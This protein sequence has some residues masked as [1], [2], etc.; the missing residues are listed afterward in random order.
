[1]SF[2]SSSILYFLLMCDDSVMKFMILFFISSE[3][4]EFSC[5]RMNIFV[6]VYLYVSYDEMLLKIFPTLLML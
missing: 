4:G 2:S 3:R 1:M 5:I 6:F